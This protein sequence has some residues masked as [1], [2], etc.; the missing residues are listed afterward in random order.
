M[1][2]LETISDLA[3]L[4]RAG[5]KAEDIKEIMASQG[6][7][8]K[9]SDEVPETVAKETTQPEA[10]KE[11]E[12]KKPSDEPDYKKLYEEAQQK[13]QTTEESLK[14]AQTLNTSKTL[15]NPNI[16]TDQEK[17]NDLLRDLL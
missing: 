2:P 17:V 10:Q 4:A 1:K 16:K 11:A 5:F 13:L 9:P 6:E 15:P 7:I 12:V 8:T 3:A 14:K